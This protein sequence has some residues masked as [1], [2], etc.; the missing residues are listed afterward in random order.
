M[1]SARPAGYEDPIGTAMLLNLQNAVTA[2][3]RPA[4]FLLSVSEIPMHMADPLSAADSK[5]FAGNLFSGHSSL[6]WLC[7][8]FNSI[9]QLR[10]RQ[11]TNEHQTRLLS[12]L[13]ESGSQLHL[14]D[15][16]L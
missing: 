15:L 4:E 14:Q 12:R 6:R 9:Q 5:S 2:W 10:V 1:I 8:C 16:A 11:V 7:A 3:K 13:P